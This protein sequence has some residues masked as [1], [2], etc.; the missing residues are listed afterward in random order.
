MKLE[1][2]VDAFSE[3]YGAILTGDSKIL[4]MS[5]CSSAKSYEHSTSLDMEELVESLRAFRSYLLG[6][7]FT[8]FF[9]NWSVLRVKHGTAAS[10]PIFRRLD[11]MDITGDYVLAPKHS[12]SLRL[13]QH[14]C[15]LAKQIS[16]LWFTHEATRDITHPFM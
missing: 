8:V 2:C 4:A 15:R 14:H 9:H 16:F 13:S 10:L 12:D 7:P 11:I 6:N 3:G 5:R 1:V